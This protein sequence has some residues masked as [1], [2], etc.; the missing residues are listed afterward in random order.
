MP[1]VPKTTTEVE[2]HAKVLKVEERFTKVYDAE[3]V[4]KVEH[5][6]ELESTQVSNGWWIVLEGWPVAMRLGSMKPHIEPGQTMIIEMR[7]KS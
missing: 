2:F 4:G 6:Q 7:V 5:G 3:K 1:D